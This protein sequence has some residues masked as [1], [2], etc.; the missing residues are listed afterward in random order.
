M[1]CTIMLIKVQAQSNQDTLLKY[2]PY[3]LLSSYYENDFKPFEKGNWYVGL[4]FSLTD[5]QSENTQGLLQKTLDGDDLSYNLLFKGGYY[6]GD[7]GMVGLN[8]NYYQSKYERFLFRDP[9]TIQSN[10]LTRGFSFTP[11]LRTSVPLTANERLS[12]F[13][14]VG[15][16]FGIENSNSRSIMHVD[17]ISKTL[18]TT[19]NFGLG[20]SPG[21]TFF[22]MENFAFEV[23][24][25]VLGYDLKVTETTID[26][27]E[28]SQDIRQNVNFS[29]DILSLELGLAYYFGTGNKN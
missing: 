27:V 13:T 1:L 7:Y 26:G 21:I 18:S 11:N 23:Q 22:A 16:G 3:D 17:E 28:Q 2:S 24:L 15:L 8:V 19:Y 25:N 20:I 29:I 6:T 9:D 12:F 10:S 5:K 4:A 14:M